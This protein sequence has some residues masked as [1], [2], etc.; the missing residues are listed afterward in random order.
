MP[1][2]ADPSPPRVQAYGL[3]Q[4]SPAEVLTAL[5]RVVAPEQVAPLWSALL[6]RAQATGV[7]RD[8]DSVGRLID[9][10]QAETDPVVVLCGRSLR[11]RLSSFEHLAATH[12]IIGGGTV[13]GG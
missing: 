9:A 4:M 2:A 12:A 1:P 5:R 7:E 3:N 10:M 11:I 13:I 8:L 6:A